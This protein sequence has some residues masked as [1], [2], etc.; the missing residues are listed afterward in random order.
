MRQRLK[1][2]IESD[3]YWL[4]MPGARRGTFGLVWVRDNGDI[5]VELCERGSGAST[6]Y[7][8]TKQYLPT[9]AEQLAL[10]FG[11]KAQSID[12]LPDRLS[13]F[14]DVKSLVDWLTLRSGVPVSKRVNL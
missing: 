9:L 7:V 8:V 11:G 4:S 2:P 6:L 13:T 3:G 5:E 14:L 10:G 1:S 12:A